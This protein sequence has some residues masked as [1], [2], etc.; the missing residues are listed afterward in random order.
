MSI[1]FPFFPVPDPFDFAQ[2]KR[3]R[4]AFFLLPSS[5]FLNFPPWGAG[6]VDFFL[7]PE[8]PPLGGQGGLTSSFFLNFPPWGQGC[9]ILL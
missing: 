3:S 6:G 8:F 2:D 4:W 5:F 7:L 9:F 1:Q